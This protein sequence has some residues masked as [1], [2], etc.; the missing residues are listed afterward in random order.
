MERCGGLVLGGSRGL[1]FHAARA[2][3]SLG[4]NLVIV[5]RGREALEKSAKDISEGFGV[6]VEPLVGDLRKKGHVENAVIHAV[7]TLGRVDAVVA[8]YGNISREPLTLREAE[9]EDWIEAAALYL[10]S[11]SSLFKALAS[12]NTAKAT[13]I[14]LSSFTVA[15]PMDPLIVSDAVRAGLSRLVKSAA[16]LYPDR[17]RPILLILGSFK[18]PGAMRTLERIAR[19]RGE[20]LENVWRREVEMLSPLARSGGLDEFEEVIRMLVRSPDYMHGA[21]VVF[22]GASGRVSWP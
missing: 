19:S 9:W 10:A 20:S 1:G 15:E 8:A 17:I 7:Q 5:A 18:T 13:V 12:Y 4:C 6:D 22:D 21:T 3:A 16:R 11:T 2:L 14:L